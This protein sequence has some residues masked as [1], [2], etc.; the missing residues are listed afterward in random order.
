MPHGYQVG[1]SYF[2]I[3]GRMLVHGEPVR[4][5]QGER[6]AFVGTMGSLQAFLEG[7]TSVLPTRVEDGFETM[8]LAEAAYISSLKGGIWPNEL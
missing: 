2:T 1:Y 4:V 7:S 6:D 5:K 8:R 3:N